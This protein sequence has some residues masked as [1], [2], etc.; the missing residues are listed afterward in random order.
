M[1]IRS[2]S[3]S[4]QARPRTGG[5]KSKA[6]LAGEYPGYTSMDSPCSLEAWEGREKVIKSD[7][8]AGTEE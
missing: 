6:I 4:L 1:A 7:G 2:R 5:G 8:E 3:F